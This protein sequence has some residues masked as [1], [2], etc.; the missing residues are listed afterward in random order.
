MCSNFDQDQWDVST[1]T[2]KQPEKSGFVRAKVIAGGYVYKPISDNQCEATYLI[3]MD[4][5]GSIPAMVVNANTGKVPKRI[6][7]F[8]EIAKTL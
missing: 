2:E 4:P 3:Q 6:Q 7:E 1:T 5:G 8:R